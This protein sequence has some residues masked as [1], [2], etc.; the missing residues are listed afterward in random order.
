MYAGWQLIIEHT[1]DKNLLRLVKDGVTN[2]KSQLKQQKE[3][4]VKVKNDVTEI[5]RSCPI[6]DQGS[7]TEA[8]LDQHHERLDALEKE[9]QLAGKVLERL[10][11]FEE[12]ISMRLQAVEEGLV[13]TDEEVKLL[14]QGHIETVA[15]VDQLEQRQIKEADELELLKQRQ[16]E[17][18]AK[19]EEFTLNI[20]R[21]NQRK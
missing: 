6:R 18:F 20:R 21:E 19:V 3:Q 15:K 14:K 12:Q 2:L 4:I 13:K 10:V 5:K 9:L 11:S 8:R 7:C 16:Y 1:V 17:T